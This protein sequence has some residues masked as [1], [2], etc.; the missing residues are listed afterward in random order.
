M[1]NSLSPWIR[2]RGVGQAARRPF[3]RFRHRV[4]VSSLESADRT[5]SSP[6]TMLALGGSMNTS[7][8]ERLAHLR[9]QE[10]QLSD[11]IVSG[12]REG[13][14]I[15]YL[16][17]LTMGTREPLVISDAEWEVMLPLEKE[18][19]LIPHYHAVRTELLE[20]LQ[21]RAQQGSLARIREW[22]ESPFVRTAIAA[23]TLVEA[24][25]VIYSLASTSGLFLGDAD[26]LEPLSK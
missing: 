25:H 13:E 7:N 20:Q 14:Y 15:E 18:I 21:L 22:L 1:E 8:G 6:L 11:L 12:N 5:V 4:A 9:S 2:F 17:S 26:S 16:R 24:A 23:G 19:A 10:R 3:L